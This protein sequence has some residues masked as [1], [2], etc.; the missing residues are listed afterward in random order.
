MGYRVCFEIDSPKAEAMNMV[1][2]RCVGCISPGNNV[3]ASGFAILFCY[4]GPVCTQLINSDT[5]GEVSIRGEEY[6]AAQSDILCTFRRSNMSS[7]KH[8]QIWIP[9]S[10]A[11]N[12]GRDNSAS[13][14]PHMP[15]I[16][17]TPRLTFLQARALMSCLKSVKVA[18]YDR[19]QLAD[20]SSPSHSPESI[21]GRHQQ[22]RPYFSIIT[23]HA[24]ASV[25]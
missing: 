24:R 11:N 9:G 16:R 2:R 13:H 25:S 3:L 6:S 20:S 14:Q 8:S 15:T 7:H 18:E 22:E 21:R 1:R 19:F 17:P 4:V 23:N 10:C 5:G 12:N